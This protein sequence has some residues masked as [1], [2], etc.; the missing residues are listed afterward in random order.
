VVREP[1]LDLWQ[2]AKDTLA[3]SGVL[4]KLFERIESFFERLKIYT[5]V[6]PPPAVTEQLAK[7][8]A[9]VLSILGIATRGMKERKI[10]RSVFWGKLLL[11]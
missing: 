6:L 8:M 2:A 11:A 4:V 1:E 10:S 3:N 9:E 5:E 7:M